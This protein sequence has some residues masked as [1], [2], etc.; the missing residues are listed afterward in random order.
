MSRASKKPTSSELRSQG[1]VWGRL[2]AS[3]ESA[4]KAMA[5]AEACGHQ[6]LSKSE[7]ALLK[8]LHEQTVNVE[9]GAWAEQQAAWKKK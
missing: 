2:L 1:L 5:L 3:L 7:A 4:V 9:F 8:T 6:V